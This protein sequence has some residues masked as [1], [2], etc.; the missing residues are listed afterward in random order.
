MPISRCTEASTHTPLTLQHALHFLP[1]ASHPSI[2]FHSYDDL[3]DIFQG[4]F[5]TLLQQACMQVLILLSCI[6]IPHDGCQ[7]TTPN[8]ILMSKFM[9]NGI[10]IHSINEPAPKVAKNVLYCMKWKE[11]QFTN[12][13]TSHVHCRP[14]STHFKWDDR[15]NATLVQYYEY[16]L[17]LL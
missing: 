1:Q 3:T 17:C 5:I 8:D 12:W 15:C 9:Y 14:P 16:C 4:L 6:R 7:I 13:P 2:A 11:P 10:G